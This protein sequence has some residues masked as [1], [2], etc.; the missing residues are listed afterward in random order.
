MTPAA[1]RAAPAALGLSGRGLARLLDVNEKT[2]RRWIAGEQ[3]IPRSVEIA[4][5]AML[6]GYQPS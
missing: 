4:V 5:S 6:A 1:L 2:F 3:P